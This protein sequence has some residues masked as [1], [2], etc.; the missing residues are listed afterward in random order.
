MTD[1]A[2][3]TF[4]FD[5]NV[6]FRQSGFFTKQTPPD[7]LSLPEPDEV[8]EQARQSTNPHAKILTRPPP[9][10]FS[11]LGVLVKYGSQV[12][13]AEAQC[14]LLFRKFLPA[15]PVPEVYAWR[16][17]GKQTFIYMELIAGVTLEECWTDLS[18]VERVAICQE[19]RDMVKSWRKLPQDL[20]SD[21]PFIG[22]P[23]IPLSLFVSPFLDL[24]IAISPPCMFTAKNFENFEN[25]FDSL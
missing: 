2:D 5:E 23:N 9:V 10:T 24:L 11:S 17:D 18:E 16:K 3:P 13:I 15:V 7:Q 19:L 8:R 20:I 21:V 1:S 4:P 6:I 22:E 12:S 14:L 25:Y